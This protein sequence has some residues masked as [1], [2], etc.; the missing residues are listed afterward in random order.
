MVSLHYT[1]RFVKIAQREQPK[2]FALVTF[3][4]Y[5]ANN[6]GWYFNHKRIFTKTQLVHQRGTH[7][8][9]TR[10]FRDDFPDK[11]KS[12]EWI[13][14][15]LRLRIGKTADLCGVTTHELWNYTYTHWRSILGVKNRPQSVCMWCVSWFLFS[16]WWCLR[17]RKKPV[18]I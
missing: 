10:L 9:L 11:T 4:K 8:P 17:D 15:M 12:T 5:L 6:V 16:C 3:D 1:K 18:K 14:S 7:V 2:L 13:C